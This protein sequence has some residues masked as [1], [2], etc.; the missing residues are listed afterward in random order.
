MTESH[1][2]I[3]LPLLSDTAI[4]S[5][6]QDELGWGRLAINIVKSIKFNIG[7]NSLVYGIKGGWGSG[8]S[9]LLNL[10]ERSLESDE[11]AKWIIMHYNAWQHPKTDKVKSFLEEFANNIGYKTK[12][13]KRKELSQTILKYAQIGKASSSIIGLISL[14]ISLILALLLGIQTSTLIELIPDWI[15]IIALIISIIATAAPS[16]LEPMSKVFSISASQN[17]ETLYKLKKMINRQINNANLNIVIF[18]DDLDRLPPEEICNVFQIIKCNADFDR[19]FYI[20]AFDDNIVKKALKDKYIDEYED[21]SDKIVQ[22]SFD[23]PPTDNEKL[24]KMFEKELISLLQKLPDTFNEFWGKDH[25]SRMYYF[26]IA[27]SFNNIRD[28]KRF[29]N[30]LA[31]NFPLIFNQDVVEVNPVDFIALEV[32]RIKHPELYL[33]IRNNKKIFVHIDSPKDVFGI[34]EE[35]KNIL[36][37]KFQEFIDSQYTDSEIKM[38]ILDALYLIFPRLK[39]LKNKGDYSYLESEDNTAK[40]KICSEA[41]FDRYFLYGNYEGDIPNLEITNLIRRIGNIQMESEFIEKY[42][43]TEQLDSILHRIKPKIAH[44]L[45]NQKASA[46]SVVTFYFKAADYLPPDR[47]YAGEIPASWFIANAIGDFLSGHDSDYRFNI[48]QDSINVSKAISPILYIGLL[49]AEHKEEKIIPFLTISQIEILKSTM[50]KRGLQ[51]VRN[52]DGVEHKRIVP[53][54]YYLKEWAVKEDFDKCLSIFLSK[55]NNF[56]DFLAAFLIASK[57]VE[58]TGYE[59][60]PEFKYS[61]ERMDQIIDVAEVRQMIFN[62]GYTFPNDDS[63]RAIAYRKFYDESP[64]YLSNRKQVGQ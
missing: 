17:K 37:N 22:I 31:M 1:K 12:E 44:D 25:W 26:L 47:N 3:K 62:S 43:Y 28:I 20:A 64:D 32:I 18:M 29:I 35:E 13:K 14:I 16:I 54:L 59:T 4:E 42:K 38:K 19:V 5:I 30:A 34:T 46:N 6:D 39:A 9:S 58:H 48:I 63:V 27:Y 60:L 33:F 10:I 7:S 51:W 55:E 2:E 52:L 8:K 24:D 23:M 49:E 40:L 53:I 41:L 50:I 36:W 11:D 21:F 56:L 57:T 15:V 45:K 61:F